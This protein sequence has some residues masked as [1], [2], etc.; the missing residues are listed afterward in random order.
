MKTTTANGRFWTC[1]LSATGIILLAETGML[2]RVHRSSA[3]A[4]SRWQ[5]KLHER[6]EYQ[7]LSPAPTQES[8]IRLETELAG[9]ERA[10]ARATAALRAEE[11]D[12]AP[13]ESSGVSA[14]PTDAFFELAAFVAQMRERAERDG[15]A[16]KTGERFGFSAYAEEPPAADL[17]SPILR[18]KRFAETVLRMLFEARPESLVSFQRE[19]LPL[20]STDPM[21]ARVTRTAPPPSGPA[22]EDYFTLDPQRSLRR[23]GLVESTAFRMVFTGMTGTLRSFLNELTAAPLPLVVRSVGIERVN[24][25]PGARALPR[26][27]RAASVALGG[28]AP[29]PNF[30]EQALVPVVVRTPSKYTVILEVVNFVGRVPDKL[31]NGRP[32]FG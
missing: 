22:A 29:A 11:G 26:Q 17:A 15:V 23:A 24:G 21:G 1:L 18:Q 14:A 2:V 28:D 7:G 12:P 6:D 13:A 4:N 32:D 5:S 25:E 27:E 20:V 16:L 8:A 19:P 10:L 3:R 9:A 30:T 31:S